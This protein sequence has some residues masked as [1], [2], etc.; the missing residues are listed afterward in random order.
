MQI[1]NTLTVLALVVM[2][3]ALIVA[4]PV[5]YARD[6]DDVLCRPPAR[7]LEPLAGQRSSTASQFAPRTARVARVGVADLS[8]DVTGLS[9]ILQ[10]MNAVQDYFEFRPVQVSVPLDVWRRERDASS[11]RERTFLVANELAEQLRGEVERLSIDYLACVTNWWVSESAGGDQN[12][13]GWWSDERDCPVFV[14]STAGLDLQS[15]LDLLYRTL[16]NEFVACCGGFLH[17][18]HSRE[19]QGLAHLEGPADSVFRYDPERNPTTILKP[20]HIHQAQRT[21]LLTT[22]PR[23]LSPAQLL[24]ALESLLVVG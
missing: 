5:L 22:L 12:L 13:L 7:R 14:L 11:G 17:D 9:E 3:F 4:V 23:R 6:P 2:S 19:G 10:R 20:L 1:L 21:Q 18:A 15:K 8:R 24:A 16:V